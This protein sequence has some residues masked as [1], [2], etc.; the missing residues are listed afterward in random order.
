MGR[1]EKNNRGKSQVEFDVLTAAVMK[2][3]FF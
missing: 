2:S 1:I 3:S